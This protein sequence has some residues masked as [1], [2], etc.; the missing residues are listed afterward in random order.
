[1]SDPTRAVPDRKERAKVTN[2]LDRR[3]QVRRQP[4]W[5]RRL[6]PAAG[7]A[8]NLG[9]GPSAAGPSEAV[10]P[11]ANDGSVTSVGTRPR[12]STTTAAT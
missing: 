1:M 2:V 12:A 3:R 11:K 7:D 4:P 5:S 8:G 6:E 10:G 9:Q